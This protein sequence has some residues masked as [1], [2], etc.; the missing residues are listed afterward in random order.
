MPR[1]PKSDPK[2]KTAPRKR[3]SK[4]VA[5]LVADAKAADLPLT[6]ASD[7]PQPVSVAEVAPPLTDTNVALPVAAPAPEERPKWGGLVGSYR[8]SVIG[9][10]IDVEGKDVVVRFRDEQPEEV[11]EIFRKA[12]F[13]EGEKQFRKEHTGS[14]VSIAK[15]CINRVSALKGESYRAMV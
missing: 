11:A 15:Q 14:E 12:G 1:K 8:D 9:V 6:I 3:G 13:T 7:I 4:P 2:P 10:R 5:E